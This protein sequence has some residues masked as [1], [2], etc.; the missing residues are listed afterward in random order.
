MNPEDCT[1][2]CTRAGYINVEDFKALVNISSM[3][4]DG[5]FRGCTMSKGTDGELYIPIRDIRDILLLGY[6]TD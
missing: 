2:K 5:I 1:V 6:V 4:F 3:Q